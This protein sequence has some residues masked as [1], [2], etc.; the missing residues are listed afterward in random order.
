MNKLSQGIREGFLEELGLWEKRQGGQWIFLIQHRSVTS[1]RQA[2]THT[3]STYAETAVF[4]QGPCV[5]AWSMASLMNLCHWCSQFPRGSLD[6]RKA[7]RQRKRVE[8]F[9]ACKNFTE[10]QGRWVE[11]E[12]DR[13]GE[14]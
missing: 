5:G 3:H 1:Y 4:I 12:W 11:A 10:G 8:G 7:L 6:S 9:Q 13:K 2:R 14:G